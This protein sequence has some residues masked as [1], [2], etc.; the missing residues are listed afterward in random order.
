[1]W[2]REGRMQ[3]FGDSP[4]SE[5][6]TQQAEAL[7]PRLA[8]MKIDACYSSDALRCVRTMRIA[9]GSPNAAV[10][11]MPELRERNM[12]AWEGQLWKD[13][14]RDNPD[15]ALQYRATADYAPPQ[16]ETFLELRNRMTT[17]LVD[18]SAAHVDR[19]VAIFTSGGSLRA[20]VCGML[21]LPPEGWSKFTAWNTGV[22]RLD[23]KDG[24]WKLLTFNDVSH[25]SFKF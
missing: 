6:G 13:I 12:G 3:G 24:I 20:A 21:D 5:L 17:A 10:K 8:E 18:I 2:N 7:K 15:G 22:T 19:R 14:A 25:L 16:G 23:L 11:L 1:M 4:L 9:T